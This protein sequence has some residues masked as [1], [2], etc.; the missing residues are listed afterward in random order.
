MFAIGTFTA[1][2]R[3]IASR[4]RKLPSGSPP[5]SRAASMISRVILVKMAPRFTSFAP[6]WRL[7]WDHLE[8]PDIVLNTMA[9]AIHQ[10]SAHDG[11][12]G[13]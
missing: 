2:A 11:F 6:F 8:W 5:P 1:R 13:T 10:G 7:I 12:S 4:S 3:S 9:T